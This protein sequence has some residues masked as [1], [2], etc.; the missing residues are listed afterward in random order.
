MLKQ[1]QLQAA[2]ASAQAPIY[3]PVYLSIYPWHLGMAGA[4]PCFDWT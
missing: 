1:L 2:R 3:I 4:S